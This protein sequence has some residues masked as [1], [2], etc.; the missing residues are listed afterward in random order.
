MWTSRLRVSIKPTDV[1]HGR[2]GLRNGRG[3]TQSPLASTFITSQNQERFGNSPQEPTTWLSGVQPPLWI[4]CSPHI[5]WDKI[6]THQEW[7][8]HLNTVNTGWWRPWGRALKDGGTGAM[9]RSLRLHSKPSTLM[10]LLVEGPCAH[11]CFRQR[12]PPRRW[13]SYCNPLLNEMGKPWGFQSYF[14]L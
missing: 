1:F 4:H 3:P 8:V 7:H 9:W 11:I 12:F 14:Q 13:I 5:E 2:I 6:K 10:S